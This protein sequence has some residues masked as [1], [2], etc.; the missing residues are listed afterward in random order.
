MRTEYI[1][2]LWKNNADELSPLD[3][4]WTISDNKFDIKWFDGDQYPTNI[5]DVTSVDT[6]DDEDDDDSLHYS[7]DDDEEVSYGEDDIVGNE[8]TIS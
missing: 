7:A 6:V 8:N 1:S 4:G 2:C 5:A 3:F